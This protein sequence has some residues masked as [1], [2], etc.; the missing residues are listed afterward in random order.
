MQEVKA[1]N[2]YS[3]VIRQGIQRRLAYTEK[4][5]KRRRPCN[6]EAYRNSGKSAKARE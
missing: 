5:V 3:P 2:E 6:Q 4:D 1:Q